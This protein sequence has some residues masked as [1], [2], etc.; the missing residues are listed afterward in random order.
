MYR[1]NMS[2]VNYCL[3]RTAFR[4]ISKRI[5]ILKGMAGTFFDLKIL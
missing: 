1:Y 4:R 2:E 3:E 5:S